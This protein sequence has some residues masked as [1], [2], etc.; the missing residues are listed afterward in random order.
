MRGTGG[1]KKGQD[2]EYIGQGRGS[3]KENEAEIVGEYRE[4][5]NENRTRDEKSG[6]EGKEHF[7]L[8]IGQG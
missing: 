6:I 8:G 7:W 1:I 3:E 5:E 2:K 4:T